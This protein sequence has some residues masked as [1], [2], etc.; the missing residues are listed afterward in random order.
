[1]RGNGVRAGRWGCAIAL[2]LGLPAAAAA[3]TQ[4]QPATPDGLPTRQ[5]VEQPAPRPEVQSSTVRV[6]GAGAFDRAPCPLD[7]SNL[8]VSIDRVRFVPTGRDTIPPAIAALLA[9]V[10][11]A[12]KGEQ[13]IAAVCRI[14]DE[15]NAALR[16]AGYVASV[17]IPPQ[18]ITGGELTLAV[19]VA[20]ITQIRVHGEAGRYRDLLAARIARIRALDP[21]NERAA[22]RVLLLAGDVPGLD[23]RLSLRP[24][25]TAPGDVIGDLVVATRRFAV[26][27]NV[28]NYGSRQIG[29][30]TT[31]LRAEAYSLLMAGDIVYAGGS[32]TTEL[33]EQRVAQGGY[34][35]AI[36]S[37]GLTVGL[38]GTYAW[39]RP[40]LG[41]LDLRSRSFIGGLDLSMPLVRTVRRSLSVTGGAELIDQRIRVYGGSGSAPLN[42]DAIR[43]AFLRFDGN[44]RERRPDGLD[45]W[46]LSAR[47]EVR[48]GLG[49]FGATRRG[50]VLPSG[51][52]PS[53]FEGDARA[54]VVRSDIDA[55][56]RL[57]KIFSATIN[58]RL[59]YADRPLLNFEE[60]AIGNLTLGR[61][62]DA[63]ANTGDRAAG[64]HTEARADLLASS[65]LPTQLYA[66]SDMV[67]L[68]NLDTASTETGR[69]IRS[70]GGGA[71]VALPGRVLLDVGYAH[72]LDRALRLDSRRPDD[73]VLVSLTAQ[74]TPR[75]K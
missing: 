61:G 30:T 10:A 68:T 37:G 11:P 20:R 12:V 23:I 34:I 52:A 31:Y 47:A 58:V 72:P 19:V 8:K 32:V 59:Q 1:M 56:A 67:W 33:K 9:P 65:P 27:G 50:E 69:K 44:M 13:P 54:T 21:L 35:A 55:L 26:L 4:P 75:F 29:R 18:E 42:R 14:R 43:V 17:Q 46:A 3:Q 36:G 16:R 51:Y 66:F 28:Q 39:S 48:Q 74:L 71:R 25:G 62:F 24:A 7:G 49:V 45:A 2:A 6:D 53:R 64:F 63:G 70:I 5:Q 57:D 22:E 60:F 41:A 38:R 40:D 15:A 73:R